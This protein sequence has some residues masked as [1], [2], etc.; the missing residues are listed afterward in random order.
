MMLLWVVLGAAPNAAGQAPARLVLPPATAAP[1]EQF[2]E[3]TGLIELAP[4]RI[5]VGDARDRRLVVLDLASGRVESVGRIGS[6]PREFRSISEGLVPRPGGGA[7][8]VDF[9]QRRLLP[10]NADATLEDAIPFADSRL[11]VRAA[12]ATGRIYGEVMIFSP[13]RALSDSARILRWHPASPRVDTLLT[14]HAGRAGMVVRPGETFRA[15]RSTT[16]WTVLPAGAII[17]LEAGGYRLIEWEN[18][19]ERRSVPLPFERVAVT[20]ADRDAWRARQAGQGVRTMGQAGAQPRAAPPP[21]MQV[22]FPETYP[23]FDPEAPLL[24]AP[25]GHLWIER[26]LGVDHASRQYDLIHPA[27]RV[28]GRVVLPPRTQVAG[29]GRGVVYL[30]V[31]DAD[32]LL[33]I[34][35]HPLPGITTGR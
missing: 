16:T 25:D 26:L 29:F 6:G 13:E 17:G 4:G 24:L 21:R 3:V 27:G 20:E 18:G 35:Q 32:D 8:V 15:F 7:W 1:T 9:A 28:V 2:S 34:R 5:L 33:T 19:R 14:Y 22:A 30:V 23:A 12:D 10:V 31:R 11:L